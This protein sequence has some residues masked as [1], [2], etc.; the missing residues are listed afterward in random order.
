MTVDQMLWHVN[1]GLLV[2]LGRLEAKRAWVPLRSLVK[3]LVLTVPWPKGPPTPR[4]FVAVSRHDFA[5]ELAQYQELVRDFTLRDLSAPCG[6]HP[7]FGP[8]TGLEWSR[9]HYQHIR[10]HLRQFSA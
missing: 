7:L 2:S 6:P 3:P 9:M 5:G 10:H 8:M 4:E 1:Q